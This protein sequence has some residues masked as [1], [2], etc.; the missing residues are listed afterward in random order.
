MEEICGV[1]K[2]KI[3]TG[4]VFWFDESGEAFHEDCK[5]YISPPIPETGIEFRSVKAER[6]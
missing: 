6:Q 3:E 1:C 4:E 5:E 2:K